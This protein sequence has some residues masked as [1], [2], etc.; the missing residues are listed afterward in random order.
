MGVGGGGGACRV[1]VAHERQNDFEWTYLQFLHKFQFSYDYFRNDQ[2]E[3]LVA[4]KLMYILK[5]YFKY[6]CYYGRSR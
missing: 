3:T 2:S 6:I 4:E 1:V 5:Q